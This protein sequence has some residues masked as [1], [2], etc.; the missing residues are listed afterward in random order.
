MGMGQGVKDGWKVRIRFTTC[1]EGSC[2]NTKIQYVSN[3]L[4][5]TM[6][7]ISSGTSYTAQ[8]STFRV[9]Q[10]QCCF[11]VRVQ[12]NFHKNCPFCGGRWTQD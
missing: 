7:E 12:Q 1:S 10:E 11:S 2:H 5:K 6:T 3:E 8:F 4:P 9:E